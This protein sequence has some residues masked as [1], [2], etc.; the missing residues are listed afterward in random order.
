MIYHRCDVY[1]IDLLPGLPASDRKMRRRD[2]DQGKKYCGDYPSVS[3]GAIPLSADHLS[4]DEG[5]WLKLSCCI[6]V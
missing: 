6:L 3:I 2:G 4:S 5:D 1:A